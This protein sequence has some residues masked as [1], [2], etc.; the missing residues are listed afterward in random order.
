RIVALAC[1]DN[2]L[3][4]HRNF[5]AWRAAI[6]VFVVVACGAIPRAQL[7]G[8]RDERI[9]LFTRYLDP[10]RIQ[11]GI[12]GLSAAITSNGNIIWESGFGFAD[13]EA[14][15]AAAP[16]T[17]YPIASLTK[18]ATSMLLMQCVEEGRLNLDAPMRTYTTAVP[19]ANAT[20]RQV[21]A[22]ASDAPAGSTYRYDGD[23]FG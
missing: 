15:V 1:G 18:T 14:R 10:L 22:M 4:N 20:V 2:E 19:D 13:V 21:L 7:S 17:P 9:T 6:V 8:A 3:V 11:A 16:H 5:S 12:P 23:R